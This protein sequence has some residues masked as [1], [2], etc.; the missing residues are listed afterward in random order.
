MK[1]A[2]TEKQTDINPSTRFLH[3]HHVVNIAVEFTHQNLRK[4][5][6]SACALMLCAADALEFIKNKNTYSI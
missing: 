5:Y 4:S 3:S 1:V 6:V 2:D